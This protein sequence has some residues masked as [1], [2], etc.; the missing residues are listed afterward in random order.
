VHLSICGGLQGELEAMKGGMEG[1][2]QGDDVEE[3]MDSRGG[4]GAIARKM[5]ED[6]LKPKHVENIW[7]SSY[8]SSRVFLRFQLLYAPPLHLLT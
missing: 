2:D 3:I 8:K 6:V 5:L 4:C 7:G 1:V